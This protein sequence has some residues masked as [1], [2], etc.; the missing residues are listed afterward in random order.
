MAIIAMAKLRRLDNRAS[1]YDGRRAARYSSKSMAP[2][3]L[4]TRR[5]WG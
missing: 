1:V 5:D 2:P 4:L 3:L